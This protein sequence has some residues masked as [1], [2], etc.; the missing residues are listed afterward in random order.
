[1]PLCIYMVIIWRS[2]SI[3]EYHVNTIGGMVIIPMVNIKVLWYYCLAPWQNHLYHG[4]AI[5]QT[6]FDIYHRKCYD[7]PYGNYMVVIL[8]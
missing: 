2:Y 6:Y 3:I 5:V 8:T 1:M 7:V 4:S